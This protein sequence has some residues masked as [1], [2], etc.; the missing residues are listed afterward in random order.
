VSSFDDDFQ[1]AWSGTLQDY[2][3]ASCTVL[4]A[5]GDTVATVTAVQGE[6]RRTRVEDEATRGGF[7]AR[8]CELQIN[9]DDLATIEETYQFT[10]GGRTWDIERQDADELA[11][12]DAGVWVINLIHME[13]I[14]RRAQGMRQ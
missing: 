3:G 14:E 6:V 13:P 9:A 4:D 12:Q 8:R 7:Y 2:F 11:R 5:A 1:T 10:I